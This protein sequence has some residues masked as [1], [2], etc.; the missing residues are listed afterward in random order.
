LDFLKLQRDSLWSGSNA[1]IPGGCAWRNA[2]HHNIHFNAHEPGAARF[3]MVP[4]CAGT[5]TTTTIIHSKSQCSSP[6]TP[7][8]TCNCWGDPHCTSSFYGGRFD[9][10]GLGLYRLASN[11]DNSYELQAF[12]CRWRASQGAVFVG[13][14]MRID[15]KQVNIVGDAIVVDG[16][17][18]TGNSQMLKASGVTGSLST[19]L[20]LSSGDSCVHFETTK[21][22]ATGSS[23]G[24][25]YN[26]NVDISSASVAYKGI[27]GT[28][29]GRQPVPHSDSLFFDTELDRLCHICGESQHCSRRLETSEV[30][31]DPAHETPSPKEVCEVAQIAYTRAA[32]KCN[33]LTNDVAFFEACIFDYCASDGDES[34]VQN[35]MDSKQRELARAKIR[36]YTQ[37]SHTTTATTRTTTA[38][39]VESLASG[40]VLAVDS[41]ILLFHIAGLSVAKLLL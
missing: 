30:R 21:V 27:C 1:V 36:N 40:A 29:S 15:G 3:D 17:N 38:T 23:P 28:V 35:A 12:Q 32:E 5:T 13:F 33:A 34:F 10:H 14:A 25:Y 22:E 41:P 26:M 4:I 31:E 9:F 6:I 7:F 8:K 16:V 39:S 24:Y 19:L 20:Q 11:F 37:N 2:D 18:M